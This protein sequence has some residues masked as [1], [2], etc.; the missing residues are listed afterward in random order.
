MSDVKSTTS[1]DLLEAARW[2]SVTMR[3][4]EGERAAVSG[5]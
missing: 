4:N 3:A 2:L 5:S 1:D